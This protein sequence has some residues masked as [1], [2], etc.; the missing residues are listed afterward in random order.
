MQKHKLWQN[1]REI[2][3]EIERLMGNK[4]E[5][6]SLIKKHIKRDEWLKNNI[7]ILSS[8]YQLQSESLKICSFFLTNEEIPTTY[9]RNRDLDLPFI[10]FT[11][12]KR[13]GVIA[14]NDL[15]V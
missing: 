3:N 5:T 2:A 6:D 1:P 9:I 7:K 12:L 8:V 10:S 13:K 11:Y 14:L 15:D 4:E